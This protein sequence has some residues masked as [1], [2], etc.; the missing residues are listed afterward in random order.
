VSSERPTVSRE[1]LYDEVWAE[2]MT[3]V[4]KRYGV[5]SSFM[6]RV[7]T[8][9][10]VPRP[11]RGYWAKLAAGHKMPKR[12]SLPVPETGALIEWVQYGEGRRAPIV[13]QTHQVKVVRRNRSE[14][15]KLHPLLEGVQKQLKD[16]RESFFTEFIKP[17][18]R[19]SPDIVVSKHSIDRAI[20]IANEL[21]LL[22][23]ERGHRV[24]LKPPGPY[25]WRAAVDEREKG[26]RE[27]HYSDLWSPTRPTVVFIGKVAVGL[28]IFEM[29]EE[30][31][32]VHLDDTY[33]KVSD[34]T[35]RQSKR[36]QR[37]YGW[38]SV[39]EMPT[40]RLCIQ[41]YSPYPGAGW[42][43]QWRESKNGDFPGKLKGTVKE[44]EA[45]TVTIVKLLGEAEKR[46]EIERQRRRELEI[47]WEAEKLERAKVEAERQRVQSI[48][49]SRDNLLRVIR[50]WSEANGIL[51][52]FE[53]IE[54]LASD[55]DQE[56]RACIIERL[57]LARQ[58]LG[59][60]DPLQLLR[61]W[62]SPEERLMQ[63]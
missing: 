10:N 50:G 9:L 28:T 8:S 60:V 26:G 62:K 4:A 57:E 42:Q 43:R 29:T 33:V 45:E 52:F 22:F 48:K 58:L 30:V 56:E 17:T 13:L 44:V 61:L 37:G 47:H 53:E 16:G 3:T 14:L 31:E 12:P 15:P 27:R 20:E 38:K 24:M 46:A 18:K 25:M 41:F 5:S 54:C 7:C 35:L 40:G 1:L 63:D 32:V 23:E 19:I 39:R 21:Y 51:K 6:A 49:E 2:P 36:V 55:L 34:L 59:N 11:D